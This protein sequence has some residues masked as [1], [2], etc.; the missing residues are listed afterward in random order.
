MIVDSSALCALALK[1][2]D[3]ERY[4]EALARQLASIGAPTAAEA[5][6]ILS[7]RLGEHGPLVVTGLL[8]RFSIEVIPFT[9]RH[10]TLAVAAY[11]QFGRGRHRASLNF[12][13][14][15]AYAV[16]RAT[17]RPL[18][19][20]GDAFRHT[21]IEPAIAVPRATPPIDGSAS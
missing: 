8:D 11:R 19:Y 2:P 3:Y 6:T 5:A 18:L 12:G 4:L 14:C 9:P 20:T 10:W 17:A 15:L 7:G 13:D 16:A 1:E 21:D